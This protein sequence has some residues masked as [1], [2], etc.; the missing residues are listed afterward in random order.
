MPSANS[1]NPSFRSALDRAIKQNRSGDWQRSVQ[2][3]RKLLREHPHSAAAHGYLAA[4][5]LEHGDDQSA[6]RHFRAAAR[7]NP[8]SEKASLGLFHSL[9]SLDREGAAV[10]EMRRFLSISSSEEYMRLLR[11]LIADNKLVPKS[12]MARAG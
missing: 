4:V 10:A 1:N 6:A 3:L 8:K 7:L 5:Y 12:A 11:D 2:L 9:W